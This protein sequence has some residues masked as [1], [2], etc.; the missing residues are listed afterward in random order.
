MLNKN[1]EKKRTKNIEKKRTKN[2]EKKRTKNIEK[3]QPQIKGGVIGR[4]PEGLKPTVPLVLFPV[5]STIQT[6]NKYGGW[7]IRRPGLQLVISA[8]L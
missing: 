5:L 3:K 7:F 4:K 6:R 1:I 2:I 8:P